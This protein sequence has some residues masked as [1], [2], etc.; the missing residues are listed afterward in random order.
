MCKARSPRKSAEK[1]RLEGLKT[2]DQDFAVHGINRIK[3]RIALQMS[4][5]LSCDWINLC[6][7]VKNK[8]R[9]N[10]ELSLMKRTFLLKRSY[11][12]MT[13]NMELYY[14]MQILS[15]LNERY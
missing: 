13:S 2:E 8:K 12:K 10:K 14:H 6:H 4:L 11:N 3:N 15:K 1:V 7:L 5:C 9:L